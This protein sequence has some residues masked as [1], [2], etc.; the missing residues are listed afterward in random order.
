MATAACSPYAKPMEGTTVRKNGLRKLVAAS[1]VVRMVMVVKSIWIVCEVLLFDN[2]KTNSP[3][4]IPTTITQQ[5][6]SIRRDM[7]GKL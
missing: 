4:L 2:F 1:R 6:S 3:Y 5:D 7:H